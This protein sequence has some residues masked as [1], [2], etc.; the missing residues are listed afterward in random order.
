MKK[1]AVALCLTLGITGAALAQSAKAD[2]KVGTMAN[3]QGAIAAWQ[4]VAS[5][6]IKTSAVSDLL[7]GVSM[8]TTLYTNTVVASK[9]YEKSSSTAEAGIEVLVKIDGVEAQPGAVTFDRRKQTMAAVLDGFSCTD[10]NQDGI[11]TY[12]E[13][14]LTPE[15][16]Q[17]ILDTTGSHHFN[18]A[19]ANVG[20]GTHNIEVFARMK[21]YAEG[22]GPTLGS[23]SAN[24]FIGK[25]S[26][27][28]ESVRMVNFGPDSTAQLD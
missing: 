24:A 19:Q 8:E 18:F 26:L 22:S 27:A 23:A 2:L 13:C 4:K 15:E 9:N 11:V 14:S 17:L 16:I 21:T 6:T 1:L 28:V 12:D 3:V 7:L 20:V 5:G 25:G 10:T